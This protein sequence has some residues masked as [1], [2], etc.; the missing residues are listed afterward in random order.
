MKFSIRSAKEA[1]VMDVLSNRTEL[2]AEM[3]KAYVTNNELEPTQLQNVVAAM[4]R[5][6]SQ[7]LDPRLEQG[8]SPKP[9]KPPAVTIEES[10]TPDYIVCLEDGKQ[11]KSLKRHLGVHG[12]TPD[13][14]KD[15]WGL[16]NDYPMTASKY[17]KRR[18]R[19]AKKIGLGRKRSG[20]RAA[21]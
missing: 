21:K 4:T 15:R 7:P 18:S 6:I 8:A 16:P 17:S 1:L 11:F 9:Q 20:R 14:Y 13:E 2:I 5:A 12:F 3:F 19:L 10:V